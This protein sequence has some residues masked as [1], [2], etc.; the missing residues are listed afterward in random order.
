MR[1]LV[2]IIWLLWTIVVIKAM[3]DLHLKL[4]KVNGSAHRSLCIP[5]LR[6]KRQTG[7]FPNTSVI[8]ATPSSPRLR[9]RLE[10]CQRLF[11]G[12]VLGCPYSFNTPDTQSSL[13]QRVHFRLLNSPFQLHQWQLMHTGY[14]LT[15]DGPVTGLGWE[16]LCVNSL[17]CQLHAVLRRIS[18]GYKGIQGQKRL[19]SFL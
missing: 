15:N 4:P 14:L 6:M 1:Y 19:D 12:L 7:E 11:S 13:H 10:S 17:T 9:P 2:K 5:E 3:F 18:R 8:I 16:S